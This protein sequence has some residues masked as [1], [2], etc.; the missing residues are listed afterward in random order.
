MTAIRRLRPT[1]APHWPGDTAPEGQ[2]AAYWR[3]HVMRLSRPALADL[4]GVSLSTVVRAE[5]DQELPNTYRLACAAL[6]A[7]VSF[8]WQQAAIERDGLQIIIGRQTD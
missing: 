1:T 5:T 6:C 7:G 3:E 8:A 2:R 4:L